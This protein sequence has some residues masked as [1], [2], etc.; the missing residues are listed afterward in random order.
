MRPAR[1][2]FPS[3]CQ[4]Q[5]N[6]VQCII[7]HLVYSGDVRQI[8]MVPYCLAYGGFHGSMDL[9]TDWCCYYVAYYA[10]NFVR[11]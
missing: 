1:S 9:H 6:T 7:V 10:I 2:P 5:T 3:Q 11:I 4:V 8:G